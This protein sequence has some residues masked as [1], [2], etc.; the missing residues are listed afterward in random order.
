MAPRPLEGIT[1]VELGH[2]IAAPYAGLILADLGARVIKVEN[3]GRGDYARGWGPPFW[4][5]CATPFLCMN[6]GKQGITV[7]FS[8][9]EEMERLKAI[10]L[11]E[12]DAVV[13]NLRPGIL[14]KF[15]LTAEGLRAQ[16]PSLVWCDIGAFGA[17][18]PLAA[19]PGY[20][21]LAQ[22]SSGIMSVTGE[23]GRPPVRVGVSL[24]DMGSGMWA[25][26]GLLSSLL[27]R[28]TTGAG[29][30][31]STSLFETGLAWMTVPLAGYSANGEVRKPFGSG[32]QEIV[33]Y[34]AFQ[35]SDGW[36]MI[37]A[38]NDNLFRKL[39][40]AIGVA[41]LASDEDYATNAAR[42]VN[43]DRLLPI[44]QKALAP[45]RGDE[46]AAILDRAG[47]PNAPL[48]GTDQVASHPQTKAVGMI[49]SSE[50]DAL[51][52]VGIPVSFDGERPRSRRRAPRLGEHTA[53]WMR[54]GKGES[55]E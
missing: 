48:L 50:D 19:K 4:D 29:C 47:V 37:A 14:D 31:V 7:D 25:V 20:D 44:L 21:P 40:D 33:P 1:V 27:A 35:V 12:A 3:P 15:G 16:K 9:R 34:Q 54:N 53:H 17:R 46:L 30:N 39:C 23:G 52:L 8:K 45:Y 49:A 5:D 22:A 43:R 6:R 18:G 55:D 42:V 36:L 11:E 32:L 13:Q 2:S 24:V 28:A 51:E 41:S 10:I 26:I 38:G